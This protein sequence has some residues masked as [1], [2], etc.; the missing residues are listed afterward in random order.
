LEKKGNDGTDFLRL[1][2]FNGSL[3]LPE[4]MVSK[5]L[6]HNYREAKSILKAVGNWPLCE[7]DPGQSKMIKLN[8]FGKQVPMEILRKEESKVI[9]IKPA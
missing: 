7:L 2:P 5:E 9:I 1:G 4:A 6:A 8:I 3:N